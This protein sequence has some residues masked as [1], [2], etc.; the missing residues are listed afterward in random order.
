ML[1]YYLF[2]Y[3]VWYTKIMVL[4]VRV[5]FVYVSPKI[6]LFLFRFMLDLQLREMSE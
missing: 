4:D 6:Q 3:H 2:M 5:L 1:E